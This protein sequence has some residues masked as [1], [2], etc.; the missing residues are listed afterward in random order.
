LYPA[1]VAA[2]GHAFPRLPTFGVPCPTTI[3][4]IGFLLAADRPLP[5]LLTL[6]PIVWALIGG[7]AALLLGVHADMM[8]LVGGVVLGIDGIGRRG[9]HWL[10]WPD[11]AAKL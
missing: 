10:M 11:T 3:L 9:A 5:R 1:I 8:L 6:V 2:E 4:T 7:S